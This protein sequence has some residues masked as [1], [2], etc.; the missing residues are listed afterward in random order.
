MKRIFTTLALAVACSAA[1]FAQENDK[2]RLSAFTRQYMAA[3]KG[4]NEKAMV[5]HYVY[6]KINNRPYISAF[7]KV[8]PAVD[9]AALNGLGVYVGTRAGSIWTVQVPVEKVDQFVTVSGIKYIEL[10][11]P[12]KPYLD[13]A[14]K[15]THAD[16]AQAGIYL[17]SPMTGKN[18]VV[19]VID[20][21]FDF[22]HPTMYDTTHSQY[23]IK[24]VWT[25]KVS[26][27]PPSGFAYGSEY[28]DSNAIR[29]RGYDTAITSHGSH[30][31]GIAAGSGCGSGATNNRFK[32]MAFESDIVMVGIMPAPGEWAAA[33]ESDIIDGM[34]YIYTYAAAVGKPAVV[35]L[36]WGATIG[37]HDGNSLFSQACDALTGAG[38][39]F[40]C[41]AGNNGEDTVHLKKVFTPADTTVSTFVTFSPYLDTA[42]QQ[43]WVDVW[44]DTG[45]VFCL[46]V[47]LYN[48]AA[49]VDS[50][51]FLCV[52]DT[53]QTYYLIGSNSDTCFVT[54]T[55]AAPEYNGKP[56]AILYFYS[57]VHDNIC[58]TTRSSGATVNMWEGYVIPPQGYYGYLKR[59]GYPWAVSGD[60]KQTVSDIGCTRSAITAAA[61]T[62]KATFINING[63][64]LG[65][66]GALHGR[67]APFSSFGPTED[68]RIKPD[69]AAPGF[70]LASAISSYDTTYNSTGSNYLGVVKADTIG[71]TIYRYAMLAGTSMASP[72]V[73]GIVAMMLQMDPTLTPDAVRNTLAATAITD[74]YTG[75]IPAAGNTTWGHGKINAYKALRYMA[76]TLSVE[77]TLVSDP[78]SCI[79]YPNPNKGSFTIDYKSDLAEPLNVT[80]TDIT[81]KLVA[82]EYWLVNQ[83]SNSHRFDIGGLSKGVYLVKVSSP[84]GYKVMKMSVN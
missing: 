17:S 25:Q 47:K 59:L 6:K 29:A 8:G 54:I 49:V 4:I 64:S 21:G 28:T 11:A 20:A 12:I 30:V 42:Q 44:G 18:V 55:M 3:K 84:K 9:E 53:T 24:K 62:S 16:S 78:L 74:L 76:G 22:T 34:N 70:A 75:T 77:N 36:S 1:A 65:Y 7:I 14:R 69:I 5:P 33:G 58:L 38:K 41:A 31:T 50:T 43:T 39:I 60:A 56:H 45:S 73:S 35:N 61:Y 23:R 13:S 83:G 51:V 52:T 10:D 67:I 48:A 26:G 46:N 71:S 57:R 68:G 40:V 66:A 32:G 27:T 81:G 19:G 72:C 63:T 15:E 80:V 2:P 37:P 82:V 79:L